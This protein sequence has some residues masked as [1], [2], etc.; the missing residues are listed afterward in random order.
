MT[1]NTRIWYH[2]SL[3]ATSTLE[4]VQNVVRHED[5]MAKKRRIK[6][7]HTG[8]LEE[9]IGTGRGK[10][11]KVIPPTMVGEFSTLSPEPS[12]S[13][14]APSASPQHGRCAGTHYSRTPQSR[15]STVRRSPRLMA[16]A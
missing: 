5:G 4:D 15:S 14:A 1:R 11:A 9:G 13:E 6:S 12:S 8:V 16:Q 7:K 3:V 2:P 10:R